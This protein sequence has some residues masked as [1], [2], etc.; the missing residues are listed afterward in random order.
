[1]PLRSGAGG[2]THA[3]DI[4]ED[5]VRLRYASAVGLISECAVGVGHGRTVL[6]QP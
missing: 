4:W 3:G 1:M 2:T 6:M 5:G